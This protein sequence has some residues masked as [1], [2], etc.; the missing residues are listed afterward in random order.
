MLKPDQTIRRDLESLAYLETEFFDAVGDALA[1][2]SL[3]INASDHNPAVRQVDP[4]D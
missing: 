2:V 3:D 4:L 1:R